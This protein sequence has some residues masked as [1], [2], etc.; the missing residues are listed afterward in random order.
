MTGTLRK[1]K[2]VIFV[3]GTRPEAIKMA[4][5]ILKFKK[6]K[7]LK[8]YVLLSGQHRQMLDRVLKLFKIR[9]D[10]DLNIMK[11]GQ[12]LFDISSSILLG[13]RDIFRKVKP[14]IVMV[15]GD[16]TT[17]FI[18]ALAAYYERIAVAHIEAG[19]R[20]WNKYAPWPEEINR[21]MITSIADMNFVPT[22]VSQKNLLQ[23]NIDPR[24]IFI[25]GNSGIDALFSVRILLQ[26]EKSLVSDVRKNLL[27]MI[28]SSFLEK[29][30]TKKRRL[31]LITGHRRENFG[32]G[33]RNICFALK[34]LA[35][36][37]PDVTF[38][39]PV[40]LNPNVRKPVFSILSNIENIVLCEPLDYPEFIYL[41][42][43]SYLIITDSGGVQEEA[44]SLGVPV[45]V[46]R[47][48]TERPEAVRAGTV[49]LVGTDLNKIIKET[50]KLLDNRK[51]YE[52][53]SKAINPYGDG[54]TSGRILN[55]VKKFR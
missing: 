6:D 19:L 1:K 12:D 15:Q 39:Y 47:E 52:S 13:C 54:K 4:P 42:M 40:H 20:T 27:S 38:L 26:K 14:D 17:S 51:E 49:R 18:G 53:M 3:F 28:P 7:S 44:P 21:K 2:K 23:E 46:M 9:A 30:E 43:K 16:T 25:T 45:L 24:S 35:T 29:I 37:Y 33:F 34:T 5:L 48:V 10:F 41:M 32:K 22:E 31:V 50:K 55:L 11:P 36:S 8:T